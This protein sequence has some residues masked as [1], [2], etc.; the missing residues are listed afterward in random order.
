MK[1]TRRQPVPEPSGTLVFHGEGPRAWAE[2]QA[3]PGCKGVGRR[4]RTVDAARL[5]LAENRISPEDFAKARALLPA[6]E[7]GR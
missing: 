5:L 4:V 3:L 7:A 2:W 1:R 6:G